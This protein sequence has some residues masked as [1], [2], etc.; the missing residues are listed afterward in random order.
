MLQTGKKKR[1]KK[2]NEEASRKKK[3]FKF[4]FSRLCWIKNINQR[5]SLS[6][7][8]FGRM[9]YSN[10]SL[11]TVYYPRDLGIKKVFY[12]VNLSRKEQVFFFLFSHSKVQLITNYFF[13]AAR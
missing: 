1:K 4:Q 6:A 9:V 2:N 10:S 13:S 12:K 5:M 11:P 7:K 8:P 3:T